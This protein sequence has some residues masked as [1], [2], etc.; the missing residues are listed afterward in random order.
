M[1]QGLRTL[2][3]QVTDLA[4]AKAWYTRAMGV[5]P[6]FDEP[7]YVG[8]NV[9]GYE[10][11]L[12]PLDPAKAPPPLGDRATTYWGVDDVPAAMAH[13]SALGAADVS[14]PENVGDGIVV[15]TLRDP[16][17]NL[18]GVIHNPHFTAR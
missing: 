11:G 13:L 14:G 4:A 9:G 17:G 6:Y 16:F 2:T 3:L 8:F 10:L 12:Q 15:G 7:F 5:A 1:F 18:F